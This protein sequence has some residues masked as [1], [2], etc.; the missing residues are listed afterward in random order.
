MAL[1]HDKGH[2]PITFNPGD[3]VYITLA[4][5]L[6]PG[7]RL[8]ISTNKLGEQRVGPFP[9]TRAVGKLA[10]ELELPATWK[11]HPVISVVHLEPHR[12]DHYGRDVQPPPEIIKDDDDDDGHEEYEVETILRKRYNRRRKRQEWLI[13]WKGYGSERNTWEPE[14]HL[15]H[16]KSLLE[17]FEKQPALVN[18]ASTLFLPPVESP[19]RMPLYRTNIISANPRPTQRNP[20]TQRI[21]GTLALH[22]QSLALAPGNQAQRAPP[23]T[24]ALHSRSL[25]LAPQRAPPSTLALHS[26]SLALATRNQASNIHS[27][28]RISL[29]ETSLS[30]DIRPRLNRRE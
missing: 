26:Q 19:M 24:L 14:E 3:K 13:K 18:F 22:S 12:E 2:K 6:D 8:P 5:G 29:P 16:A 28:S 20:P 15:D 30:R 25:A 27:D 23:G 7:Y 9:V 1:Y 11:I 17:E 10:Y 21:P 4:K